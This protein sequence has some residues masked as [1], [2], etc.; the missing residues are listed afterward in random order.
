MNEFD[1]LFPEDL[2]HTYIVEGEPRETML[3]L[4][5]FLE[6]RGIIS[7]HSIDIF[8]QYYDAF[9]VKDSL[10]IKKWHREYGVSE[11]KKVCIIGVCFLHHEAEQTLLKILEEPKEN[12]YFFIVTPTSSVLLDTIISRSHVIKSNDNN[13]S[14]IIY[15]VN[16][17]IKLS[18]QERIDVIDNFVK[19]VK[20]DENSSILRHYGI[21]FINELE[22]V[23]FNNFKK[24]I[25]NKNYQFIL[26][27]LNKSRNYLG[28][29]GASTKMILEHIALML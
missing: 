9:Q 15:D 27:E 29:R 20:D 26:E 19:K 28:G 5:N 25:N 4:R 21:I 2:Y 22:K 8:Y 18:L 23:I 17:F 11:D 1:K 3:L 16:K 6:K 14:N 12:N 7:L 24:D 10:E 13:T